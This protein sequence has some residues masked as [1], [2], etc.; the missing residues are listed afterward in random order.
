MY[1]HGT[2]YFVNRFFTCTWVGKP[3]VK[4]TSFSTNRR[5]FIHH[6]RER[7]FRSQYRA[8]CTSQLQIAHTLLDSATKLLAGEPKRKKERGP[9]VVQ[10]APYFG[11]LH[12]DNQMPLYPY[13]AASSFSVL[14]STEFNYLRRPCSSFNQA[15]C[16]I[17]FVLIDRAHRRRSSMHVR[18]ALEH[19]RP[20]RSIVRRTYGT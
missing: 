4:R 9:V 17:T 8:R 15:R 12:T 11:N 10:S 18:Q 19:Y 6:S 20:M 5:N 13:R 7:T 3:V 1:M 14:R 16:S 2:L